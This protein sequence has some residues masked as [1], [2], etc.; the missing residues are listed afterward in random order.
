MESQGC[1]SSETWH[2]AGSEGETPHKLHPRALRRITK[3]SCLCSAS[4]EL[5]GALLWASA[6]PDFSSLGYEIQQGTAK[7]ILKFHHFSCK[8]LR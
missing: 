6:E 2:D 4:W 5:A 8:E 3:E 1:M 7:N